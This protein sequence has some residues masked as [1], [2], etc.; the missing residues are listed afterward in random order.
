MLVSFDVIIVNGGFPTFILSL[1]L[2]GGFLTC[3][4]L[5]SNCGLFFSV[6]KLVGSPMNLKLLSYWSWARESPKL[7]SEPLF[8]LRKWE[9]LLWRSGNDSD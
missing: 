3:N 1:P 6:V 7:K 2:P 4:F 5:V 9:F 8:Q